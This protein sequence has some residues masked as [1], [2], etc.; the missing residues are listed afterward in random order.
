MGYG[1]RDHRCRRRAAEAT[2]VTFA[3]DV[4]LN[5]EQPVWKT[6]SFGTAWTPFNR[7]LFANDFLWHDPELIVFDPRVL[8]LMTRYFKFQLDCLDA[9]FITGRIFPG[10]FV[11]GIYDPATCTAATPPPPTGDAGDAGTAGDADSDG[12]RR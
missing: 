12:G 7:G 6:A 2:G 5:A 10:D 1:S 9:D 3:L 8:A 4:V 11:Q